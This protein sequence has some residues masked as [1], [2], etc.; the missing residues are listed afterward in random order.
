MKEGVKMEDD[1]GKANANNV[2][3]QYGLTIFKRP[4][5]SLFKLYVTRH[6]QQTLLTY[7][8]RRGNFDKEKV[9]AP[10]VGGGQP[11]TTAASAKTDGKIA[12]EKDQDAPQSANLAQ[13]SFVSIKERNQALEWENIDKAEL[14]MP[15]AGKFK[16]FDSEQ[17]RKLTTSIK[18]GDADE[19]DRF[20]RIR[21][22]II[23]K[24]TYRNIGKP[25]SLA[26]LQELNKSHP[27]FRVTTD[28][29]LQ[30]MQLS[31]HSEKPIRLMPI[32]L[33]GPPGI[34]KT[35]YA[36]ALAKAMATSIFV[37]NMDA[38]ITSSFLLGSDI[39]YGNSQHGLLFESIV[40]GDYANPIVVLDEIDKAYTGERYAHPLSSLHSVLE[41]V[42]A[43]NVR[44]ISVDFIFDASQVTWIATANDIKKMSVPLLSRFSIYLINQP[45]AEDSLL[46]AEEVID[47]MISSL[48]LPGFRKERRVAR[49]LAHLPARA[50]SQITVTAVASAISQNRKYLTVEDLPQ[51]VRHENDDVVP[52][53]SQKLH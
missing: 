20:N 44:D 21:K 19:N 4:D 28:S 5:R 1:D 35:H 3:D 24:G 52:T 42:T 30:Q 26:S 31:A 9:L 16:I 48:G 22:A 18:G 40:L 15:K 2:V 11:D 14:S 34:G 45:S 27:H 39:K 43:S 53:L 33:L 50:I 32:L 17:G 7:F 12:V 36:L 46:I 29:L 38:E 10:Q 6:E 47:Q 37:R 8:E 41:P 13:S 25:D 51:W 49:Y 23:G